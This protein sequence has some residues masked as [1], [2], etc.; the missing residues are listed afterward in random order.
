MTRDDLLRLT[1]KPPRKGTEKIGD[2]EVHLTGL[3]AGQ[4]QELRIAIRKDE[5]MDMN[6]LIVARALL[7]PDGE[8]P[9]FGEPMEAARDLMGLPAQTLARLVNKVDE[10]SDVPIGGT[11]AI[12]GNSPERT[13][14]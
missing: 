13:A 8:T 6:A 1:K 11:A 12:L 7:E 10:L 9:M 4:L 2:S 5:A 3:T 14:A